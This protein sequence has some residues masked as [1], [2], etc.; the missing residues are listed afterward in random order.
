MVDTI[1]AIA[2]AIGINASLVALVVMVI[3]DD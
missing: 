3:T 2:I 1:T